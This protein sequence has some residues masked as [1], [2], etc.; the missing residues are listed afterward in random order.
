MINSQDP[1]LIKLFLVAT[2]LGLIGIALSYGLL[3]DS[4]LP[5]LYDLTVDQTNNKHVFRAIMGL[6][7][8]MALYWL[9]CTYNRHYKPALQT[10]CY[11]MF[12]V[13]FGRFTS[14]II[15]GY[16][17]FMF[18]FYWLGEIGLGVISLLLVKSL[19]NNKT[20]SDIDQ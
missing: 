2:S 4:S 14:L 5:L 10:I 11:F 7:S 17:G 3:P 19:T 13:A 6:Y 1:K 8:G 16:P 20:Q 18:V 15:D 12:G 9:V